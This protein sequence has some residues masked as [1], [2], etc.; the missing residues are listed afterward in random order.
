VIP[1]TAPS[2]TEGMPG[3]IFKTDGKPVSQKKKK[4][5]YKKPGSSKISP[6]QGFTLP[7]L[8][9]RPPLTDPD[10]YPRLGHVQGSCDG[11]SKGIPQPL[12]P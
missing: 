12:L 5:Q 1:G 2:R 6:P 9:P 4:N 3:S 11:R 10:L 8:P 7:P